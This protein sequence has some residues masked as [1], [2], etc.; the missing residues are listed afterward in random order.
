MKIDIH[1]TDATPEEA[2]L[3]FGWNKTVEAA[4]RLLSTMMEGAREIDDCEW[5]KN[6]DGPAC[7]KDAPLCDTCSPLPPPIVKPS[8]KAIA[9]SNDVK[10]PPSKKPDGRKHNG[11]GNKYG[12]PPE[13]YK[14]DK[15]K[16]SRIW[17]RCKKHG[18]TYEQALEL[19]KDIRPGK[20]H[21]NAV[22]ERTPWPAQAKIREATK[23]Q[24]GTLQ[25]GQKVKHNGSKG[26]PH[27][28][29]VGVIKAI[30]RD[31]LH[32]HFPT[33]EARL[34]SYLVLAMPEAAQ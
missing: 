30:N 8:A 25:I 27:Y 18:L 16:Y 31:E 2:R 12:I 29:Q 34:P 22:K 10:E 15:Q 7:T 9:L 6:M 13:L 14:Q 19:E 11:K 23:A 26:S 28:G 3:L 21:A 1:I 20:P 32:V 24:N 4:D 17:S 33:G 5:R